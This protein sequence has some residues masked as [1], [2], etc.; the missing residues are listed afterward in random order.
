MRN[1]A[2]LLAVFLLSGCVTIGGEEPVEERIYDIVLSVPTGEGI[3]AEGP[4]SL[5]VAP[6]SVDPALDRDEMVWRQGEVES[7][8]WGHHRWARPP[9]VMARSA[10]TA[11]LRGAAVCA[12]VASEPET[13]SADY[14]LRAHLE[15]FE[16]M[17][18]EDGWYG[19]VTLT[20]TMDARDGREVLRRTVSVEER[21]EKRHPKAVAVAL[22]ASLEAAAGTVRSL[23]AEALERERRRDD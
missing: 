1:A 6:F 8:A 4:E 18:R 5:Q 20:L 21:A 23:V 13:E 9:A 22:R 15:R 16:E 10:V 17:D 19:L 7:G 14:V 3:E 12:V 11:T 2:L